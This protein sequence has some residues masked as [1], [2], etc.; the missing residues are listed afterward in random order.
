MIRSTEFIVLSATRTGERN[1]V[2]HT[3]SRDWGR[4][5][6]LVSVSKTA[7]MSLFLPLN[8][9]DAEVIENPK[10]DLW[11]LRNIS[12]RSPLLGIRNSPAK[13]AISMFV[14]EVLYR[15]VREGADERGLYDWCCRSI[16]TLDALESDYSNFHLRFLLELAS[17]MGFDPSAEGLE[18]F[19]GAHLASIRSLAGDDF[20]ASMLVPLNGKARSEIARILLDY[21]GHHTETQLN[22]RSL[23]ILGELAR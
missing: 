5:S 19:A 23:N 1:L 22:I 7:P 10:S 2:I 21:I 11:R 4:R 15:T 14:S 13:S 6:F 18:G 8:I 20:G 16:A 17:I 3:I 9:L 12:A